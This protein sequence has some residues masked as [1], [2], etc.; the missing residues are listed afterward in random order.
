VKVTAIKDGDGKQK[1]NVLIERRE[2]RLA[3]EGR[4]ASRQ[5]RVS[6]ERHGERFGRS[7]RWCGS[8]RAKT[9]EGEGVTGAQRSSETREQIH[10]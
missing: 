8:G 10:L 2:A 4:E 3:A 1:G 9:I 5:R 7:G 6:G